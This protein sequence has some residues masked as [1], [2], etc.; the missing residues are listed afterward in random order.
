MKKASL[1]ELLVLRAAKQPRQLAYRF[2]DGSVESE[3][4]ITYDELDARAR[5]I[6]SG[7]RREGV[8]GE[9]VLLFGTTGLDFVASF[10]GILY[11]GAVAVPLSPPRPSKAFRLKAIVRDAEAKLGILLSPPSSHVSQITEQT[12]DLGDLRLRTIGELETETSGKEDP[13]LSTPENLALLQYTSS[14]TGRPKG[15]CISYENLIHNASLIAKVLRLN[16]ETVAVNWLPLYHDMGLMS[17]VVAPLFAGYPVTLL[18]PNGFLARPL[19]WFEAINQYRATVSGGP[20]FAYELC[21]EKIASE[22]CQEVNLSS[23]QAAFCGSEVVR[24]ETLERFATRFEPYGFRRRAL[25]PCYGLAEAT[26]IVSGGPIED[27]PVVIDIKREDLELRRAVCT[28]PGEHS[29][30]VVSSGCP[31]DG[32]KVTIIAP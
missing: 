8:K 23:W 20:N 3:G 7:L 14:S 15:V 5:R 21:C 29:T 26:L 2:F 22:A 9:R 17:G 18:S 32:Q 25:F 31:V 1:T 12:P 30:R 27:P 6:A 19:S 4:G 16:A 28:S 13:E 10:F 11:A 24:P